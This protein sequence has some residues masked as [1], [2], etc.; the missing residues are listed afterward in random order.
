MWLWSVRKLYFL[1]Q[2]RPDS[3]H[4]LRTDCLR[5]TWDRALLTQT[6]CS[7]TLPLKS[8]GCDIKQSFTDPLVGS[9]MR[10]G[11]GTHQVIIPPGERE[12]ILEDKPKRE[13]IAKPCARRG[14]Q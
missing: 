7:L 4:R 5:K 10:G 14:T 2:A 9:W 13:G 8:A 12:S 11:G 1:L 3:K 6:L